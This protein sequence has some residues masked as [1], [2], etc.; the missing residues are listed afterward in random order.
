[1]FTKR[2]ATELWNVSESV[3]SH[4]C[5]GQ[6]FTDVFIFISAHFQIFIYTVVTTVG[7][8]GVIPLV[9]SYTCSFLLNRKDK[10]KTTRRHR[11]TST[12]TTAYNPCW[13]KEMF[14]TNYFQS[15]LFF[16][17]FVLLTKSHRSR[18]NV[19]DYGICTR[20][21][22]ARAPPATPRRWH[23]PVMLWDIVTLHK[24]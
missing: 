4:L 18:E 11:Y 24:Q 3:R 8:M 10:Y 20:E 21:P 2:N 17:S 22:N 5:H 9:D 14:L 13:I 7:G 19:R 12:V 6:M 23:L 16:T 15:H 1:M